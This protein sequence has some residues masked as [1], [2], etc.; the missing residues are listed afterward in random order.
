MAG[1]VSVNSTASGS[2]E[3]SLWIDTTKLGVVPVVLA[4][5][6]TAVSPY[7]LGLEPVVND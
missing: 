2:P 5:N 1:P 7:F 6:R 4:L 3:L